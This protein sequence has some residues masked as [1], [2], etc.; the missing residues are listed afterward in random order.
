MICTM[1]R[2][3]SCKLFLF[4]IAA[5]ALVGCGGHFPFAQ[6]LDIEQG[7][8]LETEDIERVEIGMTQRQVERLLGTPVLEH[9]FEDGRW[10]YIHERRG[11][12]SSRKRLTL[13]FEGGRVSEIEDEWTSRD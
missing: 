3:P 1:T 7:N 6:Q 4:A 2:T 10:D 13:L 8:R 5:A 11:R 9:G 12:E